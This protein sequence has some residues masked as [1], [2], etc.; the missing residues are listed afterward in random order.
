MEVAEGLGWLRPHLEM[1]AAT[2]TQ[3][4][5]ELDPIP[6]FEQTL[7]RVLV[8]KDYDRIESYFDGEHDAVYGTGAGERARTQ[9]RDAL[10]A[11]NAAAP[12]VDSRA[13][14]K[15]RPTTEGE[16]TDIDS[17][18]DEDPARRRSEEIQFGDRWSVGH[19]YFPSW[20]V[21][22]VVDTGELVAYRCGIAM[23]HAEAGMFDRI[24]TDGV[25]PAVEV[26][27]VESDLGRLRALLEGWEAE[28]GRQDSYLWLRRRLGLLTG[29]EEGRGST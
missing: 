7:A 20:D 12:G 11:T 28:E 26:L 22:W 8:E 29:P 21:F 16:V 10:E 24:F 18:Y 15:D 6:A 1:V 2:Y 19:G 27:E 5:A 4:R 13:A 3:L 14:I 17:F 25:P 9:L 23:S